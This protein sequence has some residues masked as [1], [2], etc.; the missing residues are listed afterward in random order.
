MTDTKCQSLRDTDSS[1]DLCV[2]MSHPSISALLE[3]ES[4]EKDERMN[5]IKA[6]AVKARKE[7]DTS[8]KEAV[9]LKEE[10]E[11]LKAERERVTSSM[12]DIIHGAEG[13]KVLLTPDP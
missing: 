4:K 8:R 6:V 7:L 5:K 10:V 12:K 1:N 3:K 9:S 11:V 13:Y 2:M